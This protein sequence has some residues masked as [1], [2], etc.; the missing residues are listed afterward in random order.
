MKSVIGLIGGALVWAAGHI[1]LLPVHGTAAAIVT[2]AGATAA[3]LSGRAAIAPANAVAT[4]AVL[5]VLGS[6]WKTVAGAV[7]AVITYLLSPAVAGML[8]PQLVS[9]LTVVSTI[10]IALGVTHAAAVNA[11]APKA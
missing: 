5:D 2:A 7:L 6:K 4:A 3:V 1:G 8:S 11:L 10:L 9:I